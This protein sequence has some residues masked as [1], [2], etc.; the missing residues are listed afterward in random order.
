MH[1]IE[2]RPNHLSF[3]PAQNKQQIYQIVPFQ[4]KSTLAK[5]KLY[6]KFPQKAR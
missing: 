5:N 6:N 1:H 2:Q 4:T 3:W